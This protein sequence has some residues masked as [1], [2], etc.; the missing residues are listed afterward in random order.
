MA[1]Q[2]REKHAKLGPVDPGMTTCSLPSADLSVRG[3]GVS[4]GQ[5]YGRGHGLPCHEAMPVGCGTEGLV[6][7]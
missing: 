2:H 5:G 1:D 3:S 6:C 4:P 7:S